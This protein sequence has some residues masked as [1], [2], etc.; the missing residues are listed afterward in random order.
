[1]KHFIALTL[2]L[3]TTLSSHASTE[4]TVCDKIIAPPEF[5]NPTAVQFNEY[6]LYYGITERL[7]SL[8]AG[9]RMH[10]KTPEELTEHQARLSKRIS[11]SAAYFGYDLPVEQVL[12]CSNKNS[13][14]IDFN[15]LRYAVFQTLK[16]Y[17]I[18]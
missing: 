10:L 13:K 8:Y 9:H 5:E 4:N 14:N 6:Q 12:T 3:I 2:V 16:N 7:Q 15:L 17:Y 1:M 11:E 18:F